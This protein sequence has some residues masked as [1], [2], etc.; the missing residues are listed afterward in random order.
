MFYVLYPFVTYLLMLPRNSVNLN[1]DVVA[2]II[3]KIFPK[4]VLQ[5]LY[6]NFSHKCAFNIAAAIVSVFNDAVARTEHSLDRNALAHYDSRVP[7]WAETQKKTKEPG[8]LP[9]PEARV[10]CD[11]FRKICRSSMMIAA[12]RICG[13]NTGLAISRFATVWC[14]REHDSKH[15]CILFFIFNNILWGSRDSSFAFIMWYFGL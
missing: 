8:T 15:I 5:R 4:R 10:G 7:W 12:K 9:A 1:N 11:G 2:P 6:K 13:D 14:G 3:I